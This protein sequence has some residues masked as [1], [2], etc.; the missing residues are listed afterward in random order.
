M[1]RTS[2][3]DREA[4]LAA[5]SQAYYGHGKLEVLPKFNVASL[6]DIATLYT[7]GVAYSVQ[8]IIARPDALHEL[9][10][11]DNMIGVVTDGTA[12]LGLGRAGPRAAVPVME[13]KAAMFKLLAGI[14]AVP[15]CIAVEKSLDLVDILVA[16]EPSFGGYNIED[17]ASPSCFELMSALE[18]RLAVPAIHDDQYGTATVIAAALINA[19]KVTNREPREQRVVINGAGAAG[20]AT[21]DLLCGMGIGEIIVNDRAGILCAGKVAAPAHHV[22]IAA[23]SNRE[24][25][26]GGIGDAVRGADVFIGVSVAEQL[27]GDMVRTMQPNPIIFALANPIPEIMPEEAM[28]AGAAI[29][30]TGRFDYPNQCNNVLA[31]PALMRAAIDT[32][33]RRLDREVYLAAARAIAAEISDVALGPSSILPSPLSPTLYPNVAEATARVIVERGLARRDPGRGSVADNTHLLRQLVAER[34]SV[35]QR[36]AELHKR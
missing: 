2:S 25:R 28:A 11:K 27:S 32:R 35:L 10:T 33:A 34:Q 6:D 29:V 23:V 4:A 30:A 12:V 22:S 9:S 17:V 31:F 20:T 24:R 18:T 16:L 26:L 21:F 3:V 15:L 36:R 8:E 1:H 13:G 14:D 5:C 7:P 19:C